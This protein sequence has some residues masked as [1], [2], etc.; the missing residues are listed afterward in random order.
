MLACCEQQPQHK[1]GALQLAGSKG[2]VKK[3]L[4]GP[5]AYSGM[6]PSDVVHAGS[7]IG[8][9]ELLQEDPVHNYTA[10]TQVASAA[11]LDSARLASPR[12]D[13]PRLDLTRLGLT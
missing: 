1:W 10:I 7:A 3:R 13:S 2:G 4:P 12:L 9:D 6:K 8:E 11:R 5:D